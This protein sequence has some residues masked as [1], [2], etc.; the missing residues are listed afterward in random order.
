L[1]EYNFLKSNYNSESLEDSEKINIENIITDLNDEKI[2]IIPTDTIYGII[3]IANSLKVKEKIYQIKNRNL[4]KILVVQVGTNYNLE[5]IVSEINLNAK[6]LIDKFFPGPLTL[7]FNASKEF[8]QKYNWDVG[9]I[10][11][12][13]PNHDLF[14]TI[15]NEI[16]EPLFV[17]SANM[18]GDTPSNSIQQLKKDF[19]DKVDFIV[20]DNNEYSMI[21]STIVDVTED[22][23]R[24]IREGVIDSDDIYRTLK[25]GK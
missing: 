10:A 19:I 25:N 5:K 16:K 17:T 2:G 22:K 11:I 20:N 3:G 6:K 18:S 1:K 14:L 23:V 4:S 24:I 21:P 15:L 9:T 8:I 13:I 12:R 7:I